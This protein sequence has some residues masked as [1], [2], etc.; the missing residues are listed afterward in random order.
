M[1]QVQ[2][3][4]LTYQYR[5]IL[6]GTSGPQYNGTQVKYREKFVFAGKRQISQI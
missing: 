4:S 5:Y 6:Q 2:S 3:I 1:V